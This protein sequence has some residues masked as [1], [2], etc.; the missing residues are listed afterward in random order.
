MSRGLLET[1]LLNVLR[2]AEAGKLQ[3]DTIGRRGFSRSGPLDR[4]TTNLIQNEFHKLTGLMASVYV[5]V[6]LGTTVEHSSMTDFKKYPL[7]QNFALSQ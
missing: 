7:N 2:R 5:H 6:G 3:A 1:G 4:C